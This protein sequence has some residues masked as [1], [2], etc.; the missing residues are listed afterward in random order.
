M[1]IFRSIIVN[2]KQLIMFAIFPSHRV[3]S[4]LYYKILNDPP[5]WEL[6]EMKCYKI[7]IKELS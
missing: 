1:T 2:L 4:Y 3:S 6:Y 5:F 7:D